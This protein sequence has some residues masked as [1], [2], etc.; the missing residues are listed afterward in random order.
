MP[1]IARKKGKGWDRREYGRNK[2]MGE[3][4]QKSF[5]AA[6]LIYTDSLHTCSSKYVL[7]DV[8][9]APVQIRR[10]FI[11]MPAAA[12]CDASSIKNLVY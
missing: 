4:A 7:V 12:L 11:N 8:H 6:T 5:P 10:S 2:N 9:V 3:H 1:K